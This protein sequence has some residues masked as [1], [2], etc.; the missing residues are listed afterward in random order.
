[1]PWNAVSAI[2][3]LELEEAQQMMVGIGMLKALGYQ[4]SDE[5]GQD[6]G[7]ADRRLNGYL[8]L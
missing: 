7:E 6:V 4:F 2:S 3:L 1:M 8:L 5:N